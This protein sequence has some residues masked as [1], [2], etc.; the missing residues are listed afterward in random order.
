MSL[1]YDRDE[2]ETLYFYSRVLSIPLP[3]VGYF[4]F[5]FSTCFLGSRNGMG[6]NCSGV[7]TKWYKSTFT[8]MKFK[9][10]TYITNLDVFG[11]MCFLSCLAP[12]FEDGIFDIAFEIPRS[13][14]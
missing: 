12:P 9:P 10:Q 5:Y 6:V 13:E 8:S 3:Q 2:N 4:S 1:L 14:Y 11:A 7:F